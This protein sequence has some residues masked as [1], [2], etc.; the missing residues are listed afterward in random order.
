MITNP[1]EFPFESFHFRAILDSFPCKLAFLSAKGQVVFANRP[2]REKLCALRARE[3]TN[4]DGQDGYR[5]D[6]LLESSAQDSPLDQKAYEG[7]LSVLNGS[8]P[9][10]RFEYPVNDLNEQKWFLMFATAI[11]GMPETF[12]LVQFDITEHRI[13]EERSQ[14]FATLLENHSDAAKFLLQE[15]DGSYAILA[16]L[17]KTSEGLALTDS[18]FNILFANDSLHAMHDYE[19]GELLGRNINV[20][21]D[22]DG[23]KSHG[24]KLPQQ[25]DE[26]AFDGELINRQKDGLT[27]PTMVYKRA[28]SGSREISGHVWTF[29]DISR[30]KQSEFEL[31]QR[32]G[33]LEAKIRQLNCLYQISELSARPKITLSQLLQGIVESIPPA[34]RFPDRIGATIRVGSETFSTMPSDSISWERSFEIRV[35]DRIVATLTICCA[36]LCLEN[37]T[38]EMFEDELSL[39]GSVGEHLGRLIERYGLV[40]ELEQHSGDHFGELSRLE[41]VSGPRLTP[42]ASQTYGQGSLRKA[43]PKEF[44]IL[45]RRYEDTLELLLDQKTYKVD[46]NLSERL[47]DIATEIGFLRGGPRDVIEL[48]SA[49]V[50]NKTVGVSRQ[51]AKAYLS[52][53]KFLAFGLLGHL[54]SFY[55][56]RAVFVMEK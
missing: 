1:K 30:L 32:A 18:N 11:D 46:H 10:F 34:T 29:H 20:L 47:R 37:E 40:E 21:L 41:V 14:V 3:S 12:I 39:I 33:E 38:F 6:D 55:M 50:R 49:A 2:W 25:E 16:M 36:S 24:L 28:F 51:K 19:R 52:E 4:S 8:T 56:N 5:L 35:E 26:L 48:H 53:G 45:M 42:I 43:Q 23:I 31:N 15:P 22:S 17:E 27:F 54:T 9:R 13:A 44:G 7:V